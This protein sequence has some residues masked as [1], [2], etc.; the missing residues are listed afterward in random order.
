MRGQNSLT[1]YMGLHKLL[2][3]AKCFPEKY[4]NKRERHIQKGYY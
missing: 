4:D 2:F 3:G 1:F